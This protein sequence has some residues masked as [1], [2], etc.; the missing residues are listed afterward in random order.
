MRR[1]LV[2]LGTFKAPRVLEDG[3]RPSGMPTASANCSDVGNCSGGAGDSVSLSA[4]RKKRKDSKSLSSERCMS[5]SPRVS[6]LRLSPPSA[7]KRRRDSREVGEVATRG[8]AQ[9]P[10]VPCTLD[11][12][13]VA[14]PHP[15][16]SEGNHP[17]G[18]SEEA[19]ER[20]MEED[21]RLSA[22]LP[23]TPSSIGAGNPPGG[24]FQ[25]CPPSPS[26]LTPTE[27][28]RDDTY[29]G[30]SLSGDFPSPDKSC[31]KVQTVQVDSS[32][33]PGSCQVVQ[34][35][36]FYDLPHAVKD[37]LASKRGIHRL[38][39]WQHD[40]LMRDDARSG[41]S[42]VYSMPTSGGKTL[43]AELF[44]LRCLINNKKSCF[45]ILPYVSLA[46]EK[47]ESLRPL[48][49]ALGFAV[50]GHYGTHGRLPLPKRTAV[51]VCTIEKAN[52]L[53]NHMLESGDVND[54]GTAVVDELHMIGES[55]RGAILELFLSKVLCLQH[56]V[57]IIGMS[58]TIPNLPSLAKWLRADCYL[59][60]FRPV[61]LRQYVVMDGEVLEDFERADRSLVEAGCK[62]EVEQLLLL[63]T[64]L[65]NASVLVF[66]ASRQ[67]CVDTARLIAQNM[68]A[69]RGGLEGAKKAALANIVTELCQLG[70][71]DGRVLSQ[72]VPHGVAYHHGGL[73]SEERDL[74]EQAYRQRHVTILCCTSTLAAG[75]N[76][77]ARRVI[78]KTPYVGRD[79]LTKAR[80]LQMCGRA[81]RAGLDAF[82]E[83]FLFISRRDSQRGRQLMHQEVEPCSS[84][85]L[86]DSTMFEKAIL[87]C[88]ATGIIRLDADARRWTDSVF[89]QH[90][91]GPLAPIYKA[92]SAQ[93]PVSL[94]DLF[95]RALEKLLQEG[96]V[97]RTIQTSVDDAR[98]ELGVSNANVA[99]KPSAGN[100]SE[101]KC[102][103]FS[104][105]PFGLCSVRSCFGT[106]EAV[107][108]R[109][110]LE[111]LQRSGLILIDD[112]H[113]CYFLTP[114][115]EIGDCDWVAYRDVLSRLSD[116]RQR[117]AQMLGVD[118]CF[119]QQ[120][121]MGLSGA[122]G[123][124]SNL[125][126]TTRRFFV[127]MMLADLL[128]EVPVAVIEQ[129][130]QC[131]RG[132][133][134]S[135]MRSASMFSSSIT[136]FCHAMEWYSLEAVLA[137]FVKRLGFGVKP[138]IVPLM[139]I[140]G[141][142]PPRARALWCAGF[143]DPAV[144]ASSS[145]AELIQRVKSSSP[146]DSLVAKY[147]TV[148][149]AVNLIREANILIQRRIS[150]KKGEL[151]DLTQRGRLSYTAS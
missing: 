135:L 95:D 100:M 143:R 98:G 40:V 94:E 50:E 84:Q 52:S 23:F 146:P 7:K 18:E 64:E 6:A 124:N 53:L 36:L 66:C 123:D 121:A 54:I 101:D 129:R 97:Q 88:I 57:Q 117:I 136:S 17:L 65:E 44:L 141:V 51:Y 37:I 76:L 111:Q 82:G 48:G 115:R 144:I 72:L 38:Y 109:R 11:T 39:P 89:F 119:V 114:L 47:T 104:A 118:E 148:R 112:L 58:A 70:H 96:L 110:E 46:E 42:L 90:A 35:E 126:F 86:L 24:S 19:L 137:S 12:S 103:V 127:A 59:G 49:D 69:R 4:K 25:C 131:S 60:Q 8:P 81:G 151:M 139:E 68:T 87:E 71:E 140:R 74:I 132:Q 34:N 122:C 107:L 91:Q 15:D 33:Q 45:F 147:F 93:L 9:P 3:C 120:R 108:V 83:S 102:V 10:A 73:L 67:Q 113:L 1:T 21:L 32:P 27:L 29:V 22:D 28:N 16:V 61:P 142:Q 150:D 75:V 79:F 20:E 133:L 30:D 134:Q 26:F 105:T 55:H 80:Y 56:N 145:P 78:F 106:D 62:K 2:R 130:Y 128:S 99:E 116:D 5:G 14:P 92:S 13:D 31:L 85:L 149:S 125:M 77:P 138:D 63:A 41:G 43:V